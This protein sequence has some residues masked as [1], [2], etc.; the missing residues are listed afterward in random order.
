MSEPA[1]WRGDPAFPENVWGPAP[2]DDASVTVISPFDGVDRTQ[3]AFARELVEG[4]GAAELDADGLATLA[5]GLRPY[6][7]PEEWAVLEA[8]L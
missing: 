1:R 8:L 5:E 6:M 4:W 7:V 3:D 2:T